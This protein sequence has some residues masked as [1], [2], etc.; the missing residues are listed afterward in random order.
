MMAR[1][2]KSRQ[3]GISFLGLIFVAIV[4]AF[5]GVITVQVFPTVMEY[6]SVQRAAQKAAEGQSVGEVRSLFT[7]AASV[8]NVKSI[9]GDDIDIAKVGDRVVV[10]FSY[11]REIHLMGPAY[12]TLK[13]SGQSK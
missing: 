1:Q 11:E 10:S 4:F 12:L 13:Y 8:N 9:T 7:R 5:A 2:P 6:F 3:R